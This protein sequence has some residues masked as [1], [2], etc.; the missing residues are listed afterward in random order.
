M[1]ETVDFETSAD[2][3]RFRQALGRF[4]TGVTV[5]TT[6][7]SCGRLEGLT[8]NSFSALS[9]DPPLILWSLRRE[10]PSLSGFLE[11]GAFVVNVLAADQSHLSRRFATPDL[12][13][14][15]AI[16]HAPGLA[17]CPVLDDALAGF[18]CRTE[19]V[20]EAGDHL[21]FIGRVARARFRDGH[22]LIFSAGQYCTHALLA[23]AV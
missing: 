10:A 14:F 7:T 4:A 22:P 8:A 15:A 23:E 17:G 9:L 18:E 12:D 13:K 3:R 20:S 11:A 1:S 5:I 6:R 16:G 21:L 19:S 2:P